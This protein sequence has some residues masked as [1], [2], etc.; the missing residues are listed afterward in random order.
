MIRTF[1][2]RYFIINH[3]YFSARRRH[4]QAQQRRDREHHP[5]SHVQ[6]AANRMVPVRIGPQQDEGG[7]CFAEKLIGLKRPKLETF[8]STRL[9]KR[10]FQKHSEIVPCKIKSDS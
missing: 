8:F 10:I 9:E 6:R 1:H 4:D 3:N 2:V 5:E 7:L